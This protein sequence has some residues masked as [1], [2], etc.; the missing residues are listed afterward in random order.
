MSNKR[1]T[2]D[3][4]ITKEGIRVQEESLEEEKLSLSSGD[5]IGDHGLLIIFVLF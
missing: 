3:K 2:H 4:A 5:T 1:G